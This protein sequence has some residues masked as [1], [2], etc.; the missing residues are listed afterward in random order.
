MGVLQALE[1]IK[2]I[3]S[4]KLK[5]EGEAV[6]SSMLLFSANSNPQFRSL[7]MRGR[8]PKCVA[9]SENAEV[10]LKN[11]PSMDYA[12]FCGLTAPVSILQPEERIEAK[13]YRELRK[14]EGAHVLL[15]V[16]EKVQF[17][18]CNLEGSINVPFSTFQGG[19]PLAKEGEQPSWLP[20]KFAPDSSIYVVCR[21]GNDSQV[22]TRKLKESGLGTREIKDIKGGLKSWKEQVDGSWPEY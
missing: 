6:G 22:V 5:A 15:D 13:E 16:R 19:R 3:T 20:E 21:L 9:C 7:K 11:L 8:S 4:G 14:G 10:T 1:A 18:I 12:F 17:D 2:L